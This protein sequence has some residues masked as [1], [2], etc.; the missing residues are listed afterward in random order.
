MSNA[1]SIKLENKIP[2]DKYLSDRGLDNY[3][4]IDTD[5]SLVIELDNITVDELVEIEIDTNGTIVEV[6][7]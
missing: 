5:G 1:F 7:D 4:Y 6:R 2:G 3:I